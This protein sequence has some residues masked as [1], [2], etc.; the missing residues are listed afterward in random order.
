MASSDLRMHWSR[1]ANVFPK[2]IKPVTGP[3]GRSLFNVTV[4]T[5]EWAG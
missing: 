1:V 3:S 5:V 4:S 2:N